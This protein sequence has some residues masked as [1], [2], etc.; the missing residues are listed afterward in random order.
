MK[1]IIIDDER[2]M[3]EQ[4]KM[5]L[6]NSRKVELVGSFQL[7]SRALDYAKKHPV[8]LA[9][10]DIEMPSMSGIE[11]GKKLREIHPDMVLIYVTGYPDYMQEAFLDVK[12]DYYI[13]KPY[14]SKDIEDAVNRA[15]LLARRQRKDVYIHAFGRF[16]VYIDGVAV[17]FSNSKSKELLA[18]CVDHLGGMVS[19]EECIE[20]L[21]GDRP[22]DEKVKNLYRKAI[23]YLNRLLAELGYENIF[24]NERGKCYV[25]LK[26]FNCDY[27]SFVLKENLGNIEARFD[28]DYMIEYDWARETEAKLLGM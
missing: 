19:M 20:K 9:F 8:E 4:L 24:G 16:E 28:G 17:A 13:L 3:L 22:Y 25:N 23:S 21:W 6:K 18:L 5:E 7:G 10:L 11:L 26:E 1:T 14:N 2:I 15:S 12:S 27:A